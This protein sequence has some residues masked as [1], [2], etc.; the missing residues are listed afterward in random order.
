MFGL[1]F[2]NSAFLVALAATALP[3]IIHLLSRRRVRKVPFSTLT[4]IYE[5]SKRRMRKVNLRRILILVLRTLAVLFIVIAFAR[6][7]LRSAAAFILP[8][9]APKNVIIGLD[10]SYSMGVEWEMGTA[11][12]R[13]KEIASG[14]VDESGKED[15]I[16]VVAFSD[17]A[18]ALFEKGTRNKQLIKRAI[19]KVELTGEGTSEERAIQKAFELITQSNLENGEVYIISDFRRSSD[20]TLVPE[21]PKGVRVFFLPVYE[22]AVDNV[23]IDRILIPRKLIRPGEEVR[24]S[25][26]LSN[27]SR[28][29][30][31]N[32]PLELLVDGKRKA[33]KVVRLEPAAS[34]SANFSIAFNQWGV[35][36]GTVAKSADR[37]PL[38][39]ERHFL[40]EV[41]KSVPVTLIRGLKQHADAK[42]VASYFYVE[43]ALNP[44]RTS[45]GE[46]VVRV[47]DEKTLT[48]SDLPARGVA[49]W[50][51]PQL[52][53]GRRRLGLMERYV[54]GGGALMIFLGHGSKGITRDQAFTSFIGIHGAAQ[55]ETMTGERLTSFQKDHPI[56]NIFSE[57][58]LEL[59]SQASVRIYASARGAASD[60]IVAYL[61]SG[62]PAIWECTRGK[63]KLL[64]YAASPDMKSGDLPLSPMF[65]PLVHTSISYLASAERAGRLRENYVGS[66][67]FF[68]LP[69]I[70]GGSEES[71]VV[72]D[73]KGSRSKPVVYESPQSEKMALLQRPGTP[74]FYKL[75]SDTAVVTE[76]VVNLDTRESD[77]NPRILDGEVVRDASI[78]ET[79]DAFL[80][81]LREKREGREVYAVFL[82]LAAA[83]LVAEA[84]LG[85][86]A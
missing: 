53:G 47:V 75:L 30:P 69:E 45:E 67:L 26:A 23:S 77:L 59:L 55:K 58:E 13:A 52:Q 20:S 44:R 46:F 33:E 57:E 36:K 10:A 80:K 72:V 50:T 56:F 28:V 84:L 62:D 19:G 34:A 82:L 11:F 86:S 66:E 32:F 54:H 43:R 31:A 51:D 29:N 63:G 7:T 18:E 22:E 64:V 60:S 42:Q 41:S 71:L 49:V 73:G 2:L 3:I 25:V 17:R 5:L 9:T 85:R 83:A 38:D 21:V 6:P 35:Y 27:H 48:V 12:T 24:V 40:L 8:G 78:V 39:D 76:V 79:G 4:F 37:L 16:N 68:N 81:S 15:L 65:L 70:L 61:S 14:V 74:G 1:G